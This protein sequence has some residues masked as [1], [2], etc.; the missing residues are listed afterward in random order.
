MAD[1]GSLGL[2]K[3]IVSVLTRQSF[4]EP[5]EVQGVII[6]AIKTGKNIVFRSRTGSGK[7]LAYILGHL[8]KI[9]TKQGVQMLIIVPTQ[10]LCIQVG[11]VLVELCAPL[12]IST[13]AL[14]GGRNIAG[15][16]RTL[17]KKTQI[18][19]GTPGRLL[20]HVN[21]KKLRIGDTKYIVFD[22]SDQMFDHGFFRDCVYLRKRI[23][24]DAQIILSSAT[25]TEQ[26]EKFVIQEIK[27]H[28][29]FKI[30]ETVPNTITQEKIY[31]DK[32]EKNAILLDLLPKKRFR[33]TIIFCNTK[34]KSYNIA[35]FLEKNGFAAKSFNGDLEHVERQE[36]LNLF[37]EGKIKVLVT[38]DV[39][40]RGLHIQQVDGVINYDVSTRDEFYIHRIGRTGRAG[41]NGYALTLICPEDVERFEGIEKVYE[42]SVPEIQKPKIPQ[43]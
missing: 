24:V 18:I 15:D 38:T 4:I 42:I 13:G 41:K 31:C 23:S 32:L 36:H 16:Y 28:E 14:Y 22:E 9:N 30:G 17:D 27:E 25:I 19:V 11:K 21:D 34:V 6:P 39:A 10:E 12:G 20:Q 2:K 37:K 40:A 26:V 3:D 33:R 1:F 35:A 43:Q 29:F 8:G 7:T 5:T